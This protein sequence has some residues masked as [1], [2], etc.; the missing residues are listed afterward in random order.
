[1]S[2]QV[3]QAELL[4]YGI[5]EKFS[6]G[7]FSRMNLLIGENGTGKTI[8]LKALYTAIRCMEEYRR[9]N[10]IRSI[11]EVLADKLRWTFQVDKLG[12][13]VN[14]IST[15]KLSLH[16]R[17]ESES[18]SYTFSK[19]TTRKVGN[20]E[21]SGFG[22]EGNSVFIPAREILSFF[23]VIFRSREVDKAFG[24]DDTYVDLAKALSISPGRGKNDKVLAHS[25]KLMSSIMDGKVEYDERNGTWF[26]KNKKNQRFSLGT[27]S[28]GVKKMQF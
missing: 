22:K 14:K 1:M 16:L 4:N 9:G 25:R 28:E 3:K 2:F 17:S 12:E 7:S 5:F 24:F 26:Y 21:I 15:D 11:H 27:V 8:L 23:S 6:C 10:D 19:Y 20:A 18:L 13:L